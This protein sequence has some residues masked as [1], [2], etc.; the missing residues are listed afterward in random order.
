VT[1][2]ED[3]PRDERLYD[4]LSR[5]N[6]ELATLQREMAQK[7]V[8]LEK[9]SAE[10][11]RLL[12]MAAHDLRSP[13]GVIFAYSEFLESEAGERLTPEEREFIATIQR[14]SRFML[15]LVE[16]LLDVSALEAGRLRLDLRPTDLGDLVRRNVALN[17]VLAAPKNVAVEL[18]ASIVPLVSVDPGKIEQV[19]NNLIGNAVKFSKSG[20][21]VV[22]R[23]DAAEGEVTVTVADQGEG[24]AA[25]DLP[26]LFQPF[27]VVRAR[28]TAGERS[29]G[30]GLAIAR[31]IVE[32]HGGRIGVES[33]AGRGSTFSFAIPTDPGAHGS[34]V[35][36]ARPAAL[37]SAAAA[38]RGK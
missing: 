23:L 14:T 12:G 31:R 32:G 18:E 21:V 38:Q 24:I 25:A 22:V 15:E 5:L 34:S 36:C 10:K 29:T 6:N 28:G 8:E 33:E 17:A 16:D 27:G 3:D 35:T 11:S 13:L 30:L 26:R 37:G 19:L 2:G 7:N 1:R 9:L 4:D 20:T